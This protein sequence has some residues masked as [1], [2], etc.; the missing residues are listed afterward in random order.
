LSS[1]AAA[2]AATNLSSIDLAMNAPLEQRSIELHAIP[3]HAGSR[4]PLLQTPAHGATI[5]RADARKC[6]RLDH[7]KAKGFRPINRKQQGRRF[8]QERSKGIIDPTKL[9]RAALQDAASVAGLLVTT[10]ALVA[11]LPKK[12][13]PPAAPGAGTGM[14]D[15]DY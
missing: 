14:G 10:E 6:F 2:T 13:A 5:K 12:K 11:G 9:V 1:A 15:M 4:K 7:H 3:C 8:A